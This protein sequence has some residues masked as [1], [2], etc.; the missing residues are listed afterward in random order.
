[1]SVDSQEPALI[2]SLREANRLQFGTDNAAERVRSGALV[3]LW[4]LVPLAIG[5]VAY[6]I[7]GFLVLLHA[8]VFDDIAEFVIIGWPWLILTLVLQAGYWCW[9]SRPWQ[10]GLWALIPLVA[11]IPT[12]GIARTVLLTDQQEEQATAPPLH[13]SPTPPSNA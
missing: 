8:R 12:F 5:A 4:L 11:L 3:A 9:L 10:K 2:A 6:L 13:G 7:I 1:M